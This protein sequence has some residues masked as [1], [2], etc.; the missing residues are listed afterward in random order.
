MPKF[1]IQV[2]ATEE[3]ESGARPKTDMLLKM[4]EYNKT[5]VDAGMLIDGNGL[6]NSTKGARIA[7]HSAG[8]SVVTKGPF[9]YDSLVSGYWIW[10]AK[11][12][13]EAISWAQKAP[14]TEGSI[15]EVRQV[16]GPDD[17]GDQM[18]AEVKAANEQLRIAL[19]KK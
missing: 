4:A 19:E 3:G 5:L 8:A 17:F 14:F 9:A 15:L 10:E 16:A 11:D 7:F 18:T 1:M 6:L 2:R 13:Q 12:L